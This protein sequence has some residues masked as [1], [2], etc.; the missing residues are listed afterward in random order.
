MTASYRPSLD[1]VLLEMAY[2]M[3]LRGTCSRARI[4]TVIAIDGRV[5]AT[6]FNGSPRGL[7]HCEHPP[8]ERS[9]DDP[10]DAPP[11]RTAVHAEANAL[12][13]AARHGVALAGATLYTT[14]SPC[15]PC[16]MLLVNA[17]ITRVI[18][19]VEYRDAGGVDLLQSAD[20]TVQPLDQLTEESLIVSRW[21][22]GTPSR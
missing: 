13:F 15:V 5:C 17:G 19:A 2:A 16:A 14:M 12:V 8:D 18:Y 10:A 11:C 20:V 1:A 4:G 9:T 6:G 7:P 3:S 22:P 21:D